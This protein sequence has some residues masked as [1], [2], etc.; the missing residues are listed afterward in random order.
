MS[1]RQ[2]LPRPAPEVTEDGVP[3]I[4]E[5]PED[6]LLTGDPVEGELPPLDHPQGVTDWGTTASEQL[7]SEPMEVR[8]RREVPD[9]EAA[10]AYLDRQ[11]LE[12]GADGGLGDDEADS[13]GEV[14]MG[15]DDTLSAEEA[16][17]QVVDEPPGMNYDPDPGYVDYER[18]A[19]S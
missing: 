4:E 14:D 13:L 17:M 15:L 1:D 2:N 11:I 19:R 10:D 3:S 12:P 7:A 5:I 16:A 8:A 6:V 9:V 18:E